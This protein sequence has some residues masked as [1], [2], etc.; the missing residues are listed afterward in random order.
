MDDLL[1]ARGFWGPR[2]ESPEA[3]A[4]ELV[5]FL[6]GL[7]ELAGEALAWTS[8][9]SPGE[10]LA[11]PATVR[12]VIA[13]AVRANTDAPQLGINQVVE[14]RGAGVRKFRISMTVGGYSDSPALQNTFLVRW[15]GT[16]P[17][18]LAGPLLRRLVTVW[19]P[20]W[21][22]VTSRSLMDAMAELQPRG[23]PGPKIGYL[24]YLSAGRAEVLSGDLG[25]HLCTLE[26][27]GV[28]IG[29]GEGGG[30]LSEDEA[31]AF[32]TDLTSSAAFG[33]TPTSRSKF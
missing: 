22:A 27:G 8:H 5:T 2:R 11:E 30:F 13:D 28:V 32:A 12:Q 3:I 7:N 6:T 33:A 14:G 26:T 20:D 15:P 29:S 17:S 10:L 24:T 18:A 23:T 9:Q 25:K 31:R 16:E 4:D 1:I 19:D 21:A